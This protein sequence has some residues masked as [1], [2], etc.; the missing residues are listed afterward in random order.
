MILMC[1]ALIYIH[2]YLHKP[3]HAYQGYILGVQIIHAYQG[4]NR[5]QPIH[6]YQG[7]NRVQPIH[8]Y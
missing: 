7:Y 3:I 5:V 4:Y 8:A 2:A 6:A 1:Q